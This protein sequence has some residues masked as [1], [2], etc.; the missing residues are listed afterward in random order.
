MGSSYC[1]QS[2][3]LIRTCMYCARR[4]VSKL[5]YSNADLGKR[6][7]HLES[8]ILIIFIQRNVASEEARALRHD[9][10]WWW[11]HRTCAYQCLSSTLVKV[12]A[13][14][15][16]DLRLHPPK[17]AMFTKSECVIGISSC[18][19]QLPVG[20]LDVIHKREVLTLVIRG[21]GGHILWLLSF[22]KPRICKVSRISWCIES[23]AN[24]LAQR[25]H[26]LPILPEDS[27][28]FGDT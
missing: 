16:P 21:K 11:Y 15:S 6:Q 27:M 5:Q 10:R 9:H 14:W 25:Q 4:E 13:I 12:F 3:E 7:I 2:N 1:H 24:T 20:P 8:S 28:K 19:P 18:L 26:D 23:E 22:R 17:T